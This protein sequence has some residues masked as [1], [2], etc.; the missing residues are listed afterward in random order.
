MEPIQL[1]RAGRIILNLAE[2]WSERAAIMKQSW[3]GDASLTFE[4]GMEDYPEKLIPFVKHPAYINLSAGQ[5][6]LVKSLAWISWNQRVIGTEELVVNPALME[7]LHGDCGI[8]LTTAE[9]T[10]IRQT[11]V[12]EYFHSQMH[13]VAIEFT[14]KGRNLPGEKLKS[15]AQYPQVYRALQIALE[16]ADESWKRSLTRLA[17]VVVGELSIYEFLGVVANDESVQPAS[18]IMLKLH[19]ADEGAHANVIAECMKKNFHQLPQDRQSYFL[20]RIPLAAAGFTQEDWG[21]WKIIF[22]VAK[23]CEGDSIVD[24]TRD[25]PE[26][27]QNFALKRSF[28]K[29]E[30]FMVA[31]GCRSGD[32]LLAESI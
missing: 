14:A 16:E 9:K 12:D 23:L 32:A 11:I 18:R 17:W 22:E 7:L 25:S 29:I 10:A 15:L 30:D 19:Q 4:E 5:K 20:S 1:E 24:E 6:R 26:I 8:E 3:F 27:R 13:E 2:S 21:V 28:E 31:V